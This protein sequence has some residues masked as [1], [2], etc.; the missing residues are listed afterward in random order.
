MEKSGEDLDMDF[1]LDVATVPFRIPNSPP[2]D[3]RY[4]KYNIDMVR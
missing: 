1:A 4:G 2:P 3:L